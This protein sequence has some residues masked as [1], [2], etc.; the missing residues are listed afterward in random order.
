M[1]ALVLVGEHG[2]EPG[3]PRRSGQ[4]GQRVGER[5]PHRPVRI[6]DRGRRS[7]LDEHV[8]IDA[9]ERHQRRARRSGGHGADARSSSTSTAL[10]RLAADRA[11]RRLPS[12]AMGSTS[13]RDHDLQERRRRR[14]ARRWRRGRGSPGRGLRAALAASAAIARERAPRAACFRVSEPAG[15]ERAR[16]LSVPLKQRRERREPRAR[17]RCAGTR[18]ATG[19]HRLRTPP[20]RRGASRRARRTRRA[21]PA[22]TGPGARPPPPLLRVAD[23][24]PGAMVASTPA[25]R[26]G[27]HHR[28][29][30][31]R[32]GLLAEHAQRFGGAALHAGDRVRRARW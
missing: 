3:S 27:G 32:R 24:R 15:G 25:R 4:L 5:R 30:R 2:D 31:R 23:D 26:C 20:S 8:R 1:H 7:T 21:A 13:G 11:R 12:A 9:R 16:D 6:G 14:G 18:S 19:H 29:N 10:R 28:R 22:R 17:C